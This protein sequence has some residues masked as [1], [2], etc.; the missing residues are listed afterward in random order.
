LHNV[1]DYI[2]CLQPTNEKYM[3]SVKDVAALAG[4]STATVSR[5]LSQPDKVAE[6]TRDRVMQAVKACGYRMNTAARQFR[7]QRTETVLV[8]VPDIGNPFFS[9]IIQG[10]ESCAQ[11]HNYR[12][13]L[14]EADSG[15]SEAESYAHYMHQQHADGAILL[16]VEGIE[17][18]LAEDAR[19]PIVMACEYLPKSPCPTVRI[20][21]ARAAEDAVLH[22]LELGHTRIA[23]INGPAQSPLSKDRLRGYRRALK[24]AG[25]EVARELITQGDYSPGSGYVCA[26]QLLA[27]DSPPTAIFAASDP[28]AIGA[29]RAARERKLKIP[30][31]LSLVGFDDIRFAEFMTPGLT[32]IHQPRELIGSTAMEQLLQLLQGGTPEQDKVLAHKLVIRESTDKPKPRKQ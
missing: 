20:D 30:Q 29:M 4:V 19:T 2:G 32:T 10:I 22:L 18:F 27:L 3:A 15:S 8:V 26:H 9:N 21:N 25:I 31:Q 6:E 12:V 23:Y 13:L 5:A 28:M 1:I 16:T 14:G 24:S 7:R 17:N 11:Q